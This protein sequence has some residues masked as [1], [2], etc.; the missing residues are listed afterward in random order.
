[1][2]MI[3]VKEAVNKAAEYFADLYHDQFTN[4]LLEEVELSDG[5]WL[6]TLGYERPPV[7]PRFGLKGP[8]AYKIFKVNG[9]T[10]E[11]VSMKIRE[12][13]HVE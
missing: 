12:V 1:M 8:R 10:G 4:V 7:M 9:E 5:Y 3:G 11:V 6:I 13:E 2:A